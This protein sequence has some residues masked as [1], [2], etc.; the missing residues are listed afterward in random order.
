VFVL[1]LIA[2][3]TK[4]TDDGEIRRPTEGSTES[5]PGRPPERPDGDTGLDSEP[6]DTGSTGETGSTDSEPDDSEPPEETEEPEETD[7]PPPA[8]QAC[9]LGT[10]RDYTQCVAL[11][12][13]GGLGS[14]YSYP[15]PLY[16]DPNY[17]EPVAWLDLAALDPAMPLAPNFVLEELAQEWKGQYGVVQPHLIDRLQEIRDALGPLVVNS[18]YRNPGYN[19][20][21]GG[22]TYSRHM[23][24]DAADLDAVDHSL[25][26]LADECYATGAGYVGYYES[27]IHCDWRDDA[28]DV[29]FYGSPLVGD[30][31]ATELE[32]VDAWIERDAF[33]ALWAPAEGW[34]EGEP[35][36][37]WTVFGA[38]GAVLLEITGRTIALPPGAASGQ[39]VVGRRVTRTF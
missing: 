32:P 30:R 9:Y 23:Y 5:D 25:D 1:L 8:L 39:V 4:L 36:R 3:V 6:V 22:V 17:R 29:A 10:A 18:G 21:I 7:P 26:T 20:S 37:E 13:P 19:A 31:P 35:L 28:V 11:V 33:G 15:P 24:G 2:C 12:E 14:D 27:H 34:D 38:D 16:G